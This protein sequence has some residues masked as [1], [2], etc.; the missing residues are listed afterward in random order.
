MTIETTAPHPAAR[1]AIEFCFLSP[2]VTEEKNQDRATLVRQDNGWI[3][4]LCDGTT[5]SMHSADAAEIATLDPSALWTESGVSD[6]VAL[7]NQRRE[8]LITE[9]KDEEPD[10]A[11]FLRSTMVRFMRDARERSF[12]TTLVTA[13]V[14]PT[15]GGRFVVE[16]KTV[17]DSALLIFDGGG[18]LLRSNLPIADRDS[19]FGHMSSITQVLPDHFTADEITVR[20]DV[21]SG[22]HVVL[23]SDGFYD[24][25]RTPGELLDW[26]LEHEGHFRTDQ[27]EAVIGELHERLDKRIGDDDVSFIWLSARAAPEEEAA[28][29][30]LIVAASSPVSAR[31]E[32]WLRRIFAGFLRRLRALFSRYTGRVNGENAS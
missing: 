11:S 14:M 8:S 7:L 30:A 27:A 10:P 13:R 5:Q 6:V 12:Q 4:V 31:T 23:C 21:D 26:L 29:P 3:G 15:D 1:S 18:Q 16:A 32:P 25:F 2:C 19:G 28:Y 24:S 22:T 20:E 9:A 17:G